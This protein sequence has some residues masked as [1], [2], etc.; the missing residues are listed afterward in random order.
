[1]HANCLHISILQLQSYCWH[2]ILRYS[3][4]QVHLFGPKWS[5]IQKCRII[6]FILCFLK[7][8]RH[9]I[10]LRTLQKIAW[11]MSI[12]E[13][14]LCNHALMEHSYWKMLQIMFNWTFLSIVSY[15]LEDKSTSLSGLYSNEQ[16]L[17]TLYLTC[18]K[19]KGLQ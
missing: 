17:C 11:D 16:K 19:V 15:F 4:I 14:V 12:N 3:H 9:K 18:Q 1:M 10:R 8:S 13:Y 7:N 2:D 5:Q 6:L